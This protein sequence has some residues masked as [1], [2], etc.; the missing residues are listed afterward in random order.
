M[1]DER[2]A[3][4][5]GGQFRYDA[6]AG[7]SRQI[8]IASDLL[9]DYVYVNKRIALVV[10]DITEANAA[11]VK[12]KLLSLYGAEK[13]ATASNGAAAEEFILG[14]MPLKPYERL[15]LGAEELTA[16]GRFDFSD[17]QEI[18]GRLRGE[19]GCEWDRAQS[20]E[21]IR[22]NLIEEAYELVEAIDCADAGMM[23]EESGDVLMQAVFH[24][25]IASEAGEFGYGDMLTE[26]CRKLLDR[27]T[28]IFGNN[29]ADNA[30]EALNFWNEA[31]KKEKKYTSH[32]DAMKRVPKNL[33]AL[34][35]AEKI[36]KTA[37][38]SGFDWN[39]PAPAAEKL[40]EELGE[41][42]AASPENKREEGGDLL[43]AAVNLLRLSKTEA[44]TALREASGKFVRRFSEVERI[45]TERG[46]EM[47][48]CTLEELDAVWE[49]VK[50]A[51]RAEKK[52]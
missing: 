50:T 40:A 47:T 52:A 23:R 46:R 38:K 42:L 26:L 21:S 35:Y 10:R 34:L 41:F 44:E 43:F 11:A 2:L 8:Y 18:M 14:A 30:D 19:G 22:I 31:K 20:H 9:P 36:Q 29:H 37:Q 16:R 6:P 4:G 7:A 49:E 5:N 1:K 27:H 51:E 24:T 12:Q 3:A 48:D 25:Q 15:F 28:H 32:T 45:V 17:L 13:K 39:G 33:P